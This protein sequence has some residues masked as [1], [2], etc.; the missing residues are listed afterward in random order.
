MNILP[1]APETFD[2]ILLNC[3]KFTKEFIQQRLEIYDLEIFSTVDRKRFEVIRIDERSILTTCGIITFK[4]RYYYD[5]EYENYVYLLDNQLGIPKNVR[6]SN[7]LLLK[8]L[9]LASIM[10]YA[11]VGKHLSD[12][13]ELSKFTIWKTIANTTI[14][15]CFNSEI[16]RGNLKVHL[17]IDEKFINMSAHKKRKDKSTCKNKKRYYTVTIFAGKEN[18]RLLNKTLISSANLE[19]LKSRVNEML[20]Q[21]YK[22]GEFE[23]IFISGDYATYIQHFGESLYCSSKYVPDKFH[24]F[25]AIKDSLPSMVVDSWTIN[26]EEFQKFIIGETL[27]LKDD[28]ITKVRRMLRHKP[29][30]FK[31]YLDPEYL[32][33]SQEAQNSHIY[34]PRFGKYA[35][36]FNPETIEKL[37]LVREAISNDATIKVT[38]SKRIIE[39]KLDLSYLPKIGITLDEP[40]TDILDTSYMK[41]ESRKMFNDIKYGKI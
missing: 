22:V 7:E 32:G 3:K 8:I 19:D 4:R 18:G 20:Y 10:T 15:T 6:M 24:T 33:C 23:E 28:G 39:Q 11:E 17:Q 21:R 13:F 38:N 36:R 31:S 26:Q 41:R 16:N 2:T 5:N 14:E 34:A 27:H 40:L 9:D 35:N 37:S 29:E 25:K 30:V 1:R 12:E